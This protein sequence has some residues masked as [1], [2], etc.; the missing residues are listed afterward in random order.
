MINEKQYDL[1][2]SDVNSWNAWR[3]HNPDTKI[4]FRGAILRGANL[5]GANLRNA[6]LRDANLSFAILINATLSD[7]DLSGADLSHANLSG[8]NLSGADLRSADLSNANL[9]SAILFTA[10]LSNPYPPEWRIG[11]PRPVN[12]RR[13]ILINT[14][15]RGAKLNG[16]IFGDVDLSGAIR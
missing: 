16:A 14:D 3:Q 6:N 15:L 8:A 9:Q 10:I 2:I 4:D 7:A 11:M 12:L 1:L 13:A 5:S